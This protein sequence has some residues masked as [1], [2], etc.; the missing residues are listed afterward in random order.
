LLSA[1]RKKK[2]KNRNQEKE[3]N[4]KKEE[5]IENSISVFPASKQDAFKN[6]F[7]YDES[8]TAVKHCSRPFSIHSLSICA[9]Q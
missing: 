9:V 2:K 5:K 6:P 1:K 7:V 3:E 4:M 8:D